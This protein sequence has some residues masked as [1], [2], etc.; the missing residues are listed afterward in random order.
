MT[1]TELK[2]LEYLMDKL[3]Y[4]GVITTT[5]T[6][7][8]YDLDDVKSILKE[9]YGYKYIIGNHAYKEASE[10]GNKDRCITIQSNK[11]G[12]Y[13]AVVKTYESSNRR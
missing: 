13:R 2:N 6:I 4:E 11:A 3:F 8:S 10:I 7:E 9:R 12:I 1:K 5:H